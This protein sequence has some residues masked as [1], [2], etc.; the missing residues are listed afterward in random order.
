MANRQPFLI[1]SFQTEQQ[2]YPTSA[3]QH[4]QLLD[5]SHGE[6]KGKKKF[7]VINEIPSYNW[8]NSFDNLPRVDAV[9]KKIGGNMQ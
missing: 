9:Q 8:I 7:D 5:V 3:R 6:G 1:S 2:A 4:L